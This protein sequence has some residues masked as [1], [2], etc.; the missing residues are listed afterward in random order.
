VVR[1]LRD[2]ADEVLREVYAM[3]SDGRVGT[4]PREDEGPIE[5]AA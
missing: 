2:V 4:P 1:A 5:K 3:D